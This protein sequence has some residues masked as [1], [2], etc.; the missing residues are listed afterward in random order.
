MNQDNHSE[1]LPSIGHFP[2]S[3]PFLVL[4][5]PKVTWLKLN[6]LQRPPFSGNEPQ[7]ET[8][9]RSRSRD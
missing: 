9:N 6:N 7:T 2:V 5:S 1:F 8:G 3:M 4:F